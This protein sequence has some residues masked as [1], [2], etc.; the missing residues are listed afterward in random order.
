MNDRSVYGSSW[1]R[2]ARDGPAGL[3]GRLRKDRRS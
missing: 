3:E 1:I 2:A